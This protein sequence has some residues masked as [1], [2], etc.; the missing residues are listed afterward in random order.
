VHGFRQLL[1]EKEP[2][3][4]PRHA[5]NRAV[6]MRPKKNDVVERTFHHIGFRLNKA[7]GNPEP[8]LIE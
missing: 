7:P 8:S 1:A 4:V 3:S 2:W 6:S 5:P